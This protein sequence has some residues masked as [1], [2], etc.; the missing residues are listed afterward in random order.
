VPS[1]FL[2]RLRWNP[3]ALVVAVL[4]G[5]LVVAVGAS[6]A[7]DIIGERAVETRFARATAGI[8][9]RVDSRLNDT[10]STVLATHALLG[11][12]RQTTAPEFA[13]FVDA[14]AGGE[15]FTDR[16]PTLTALAVVGPDR[17]VELAAPEDA[18]ILAEVGDTLAQSGFDTGLQRATDLARPVT[19]SLPDNGAGLAVAVARYADPLASEPAATTQLR[20][21]S[22]V[23][24]V[25]ALV[26]VDRLLAD[27]VLVAGEDQVSVALRDSDGTMLGASGEVADD[28]VALER[29]MTLG[30]ARD[31]LQLV[32]RV[33]SALPGQV[34][35]VPILVLL[36]GTLLALAGA[37]LVWLLVTQRERALAQV[38]EAT[39][40]LAAGNAELQEANER[41]RE[42]AGVV[43]HD[44]RGPLTAVH[45][46]ITTLALRI[47]DDLEPLDAELL[48]RARRGSIQMDELI[49]D[50]L[51][52]AEA[53][54]EPTDL[55][56]LDLAEVVTGV[57][58]RLEP[59]RQ[60]GDTID[61]EVDCAV[62]ADP[63]GLRRVLGNL[64][65]N[66][67]KYRRDDQPIRVVVSA[68]RGHDRITIEVADDGPGIP[69][70]LRTELLAPF[71]RGN[72]TQDGSGLG[73]AICTRIVSNHG[74]TLELDDADLGGALVRFDL[75]AA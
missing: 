34:A 64:I 44:L 13:R 49:V 73:L 17:T 47:G 43:A 25:I 68:R 61:V 18:A 41:L 32:I 4:V 30:G 54:V 62:M 3:R 52:Y 7:V 24:W 22:L 16:F 8:A 51:R 66:A 33:D 12:S 74:G 23:G 31:Q 42:F 9:L 21:Q 5:G 10:Q 28:A 38:E 20:R 27:A 35:R 53:G 26:D 48:T 46:M 59:L 2:P 50:V 58:E 29:E 65:G 11:S 1:P 56:V 15:P 36:L 6:W 19:V 60:P 71:R 63:T 75:Q 40:A 70:E 72:T 39:T 37:G 55:Q 69:A 14:L 57:L 45:G 67:L